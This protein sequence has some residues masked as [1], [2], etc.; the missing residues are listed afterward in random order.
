[1]TFLVDGTPD[2]LKS[3]KSS[4]GI[5]LCMLGTCLTFSVVLISEDYLLLKRAHRV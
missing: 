3:S 5:L 2:S 4:T 1:M